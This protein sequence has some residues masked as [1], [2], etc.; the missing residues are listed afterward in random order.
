MVNIMV[1]TMEIIMETIKLAIEFGELTEDQKSK[2]PILPVNVFSINEDETK[3]LMDTKYLC[4]FRGYC[5]QVCG[6]KDLVIMDHQV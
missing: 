4:P 1:L 6:T 3:T 2:I 5:F